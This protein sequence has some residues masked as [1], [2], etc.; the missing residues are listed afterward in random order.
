VA[1]VAEGHLGEGELTPEEHDVAVADARVPRPQVE[2]GCSRL[3]AASPPG[4][5][6]ADPRP[7]GPDGGPSC[8]G[9]VRMITG[10]R[11][12]LRRSS[13]STDIPLRVG[14]SRSRT[15]RSN[16][17][18][19]ASSRAEAPSSTTVGAKPL[20][21][22]PFSRNEEIPCSSSAIRIPAAPIR[23]PLSRHL[24]REGRSR[25]SLA[26]D[27]HA[28]A[29]ALSDRADDRQPGPVIEMQCEIEFEGYRYPPNR[30]SG[31]APISSCPS[32]R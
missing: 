32:S 26:V 9:A 19:R 3:E 4:T 12:S 21:R 22:S 17:P 18:L 10:S 2:Q 25:A 23:P 11:R 13:S 16:W 28:A 1:G 27:P 30:R 7:L 31:W 20:A 15:T 5:S 24:D 29:V 8:E 6:R 14:S